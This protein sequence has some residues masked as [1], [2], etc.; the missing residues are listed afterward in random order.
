M[1]TLIHR[2]IERQ[3]V[4]TALLFVCLGA[5]CSASGGTSGNGIPGTPSDDAGTALGDVQADASRTVAADSGEDAATNTSPDAALDAGVTQGKG[6]STDA[7]TDS[8][9]EKNADAGV[10]AEPAAPPSVQFVGRFDARSPAG[11]RFGYPGAEIIANFEGTQVSVKLSDQVEAWMQGSPSEWDVSVDGVAKPKIISLPGEHDYQIATNLAAGPHQVRLYR[12]SEAQTGV[13]Q[14]LGYSF[15]AG[16]LLAP[17]ARRP[18]KIEVLGDSGSTGFGAEGAAVGPQCPGVQWAATW[19]NASKTYAAGLSDLLNAEVH[20]TAY[21]GK[22]LVVNNYRP[23]LEIYPKLFER[24]NPVD[25]SSVHAFSSFVPDV[26]IIM[27]GAN[28]FSLGVPAPPTNAVFTAA[29]RTMVARVRSVY[30]TTHIFLATAGSVSDEHPA[31]T[32]TRTNI[33]QTTAAIATERQN[34]G[35][36]KVYAIAITPS[37]PGEQTG[38]SGHPT[39]SMHARVAQEFAAAIRLRTGW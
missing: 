36:T 32:N 9:I 1:R 4:G 12:R 21:S 35:D 39:P 11:A 28:D 18:H 5:A 17:P 26:A 16:R 19:A 20:N 25:Q 27:L 29:Y 33:L 24:D 13:T 31:G 7:S 22:G 38:C 10:D 3:R 23:D 2:G 14:F 34:A 8:N 37:V 30:P 6:T 15:G